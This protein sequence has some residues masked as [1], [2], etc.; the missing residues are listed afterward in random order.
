MPKTKKTTG[1]A[2]QPAGPKTSKTLYEISREYSELEDLLSGIEG[3]ISPEDQKRIEHFLAGLDKDRNAKIDAYCGLIRDLTARQEAREKEAKRFA[4][5]ARWDR[6]KVERLKWLLLTFMQTHGNQ[7]IET[8][9][10]R[11]RR[12]SNGLAPVVLDKRYEENP[13]LLEPRFRITVVKPNLKEIQQ[14]LNDGEELE[15]ARFGEKGENL[16]IE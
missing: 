1:A 13:E 4:Q 14:A 15:F 8:T 11:V 12:V 9:K 16:R 2:A 7:T 6:N 3:E 10:F 5:L